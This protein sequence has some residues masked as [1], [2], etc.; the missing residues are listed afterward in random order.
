MLT[1]IIFI[2][3]LG[4]LVF[5]HELGHFVVAR[6]NGVKAEEF[7][8]GFPPR[9]VG[10]VRIGEGKKLRLVWGNREMQSKNTIYSV[11]WIPLGGFVRIKGED[12][13]NKQDKDSFAA[14]KAWPRTKIL[15]AGVI[16]NFLFAWFLISIAFWIGAPEAIDDSGANIPNSKIQITEV[17]PNSPADQAGIKVGDEIL[18]QDGNV[19]FGNVSDVQNYVDANKGKQ[20]TL[21]LKRGG[22]SI[23]VNVTP[24]ENAPTGQGP[25]GIA[26]AQTVIKS[27]PIYQAIWNGLV[28]TFNITLAILIALYDI[29]KKLFM[30]QGVGAEISGPVGIAVLT[31]Q[32]TTLGLVY[33]LQFAALLSINLGI[34]NALP[35]P[36][37]DGGRILFILIEKIKGSPVSRKTEQAFHTVG[38]MLL[39]LLMILVTLRDVLK[40]IK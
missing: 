4:V 40:L 24:R 18:K 36:A 11:N 34:I 10:V 1:A 3:I 38:F 33:V 7:G 37:L 17:M 32:V 27:Y 15:A 14:K 29:L 21:D 12:G 35:I 25:L 5:V 9:I 30:F 8:F 28:A 22:Q 16:M 26:L 31:K 23:E 20:I 13:G 6:R 39:I 2:I 19:R